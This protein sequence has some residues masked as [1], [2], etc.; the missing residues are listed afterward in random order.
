VQRTLS[1]LNAEVSAPAQEPTAQAR[2]ELPTQAAV[3]VQ[4]QA[5]MQVQAQEKV[6]AQMQSRGRE[7][8]GKSGEPPIIRVH[9]DHIEVR[10]PAANVP[11]LSAA[12]TAPAPGMSLS[13][14]LEQRRRRS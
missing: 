13:L 12:P 5:Q 3:A 8:D 14:Y 2:V 10:G 6:Q 1:D 9:I 7:Q 4:T 11:V